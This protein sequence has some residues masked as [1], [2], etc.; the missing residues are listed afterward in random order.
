MDLS[1]LLAQIYLWI[2][3]CQE[4]VSVIFNSVN[5]PNSLCFEISIW[6]WIPIKVASQFNTTQA[7]PACDVVSSSSGRKM[8]HCCQLFIWTPN[9]VKVCGRKLAVVWIWNAPT[10]RG[11]RLYWDCETVLTNIQD[12]KAILCRALHTDFKWH[13]LQ[14]IPWVCY[15]SLYDYWQMA[16]QSADQ[17]TDG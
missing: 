17:Q 11:R 12:W 3:L 7:L 15:Q 13:Y 14:Y 9:D 8:Q 6:H 5:V 1:P 10:N 16:T 2:S 4:K